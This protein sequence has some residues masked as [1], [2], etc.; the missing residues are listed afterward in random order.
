[1]EATLLFRCCSAEE[2]EFRAVSGFINGLREGYKIVTA[3]A[4]DGPYSAFAQL[5]T[6]RPSEKAGRVQEVYY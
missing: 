2:G 1:M 5:Q 4:Y 3:P 6:D